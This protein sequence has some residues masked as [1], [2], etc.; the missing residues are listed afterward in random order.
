MKKIFNYVVSLMMALTAAFTYV[1]LQNTELKKKNEILMGSQ[2]ACLSEKEE[3]VFE[4]SRLKNEKNIINGL[5]EEAR[6]N[7]EACEERVHQ[8]LDT[9][10]AREKKSIK[11][12]LEMA[13]TF[14]ARMTQF[15][16]SLTGE[17]ERMLKTLEL[18]N[19]RRF[20]HERRIWEKVVR[21]TVR[22]MRGQALRRL[23]SDS[24]EDTD[25]G[26]SDPTR[27]NVHP[28]KARTLVIVPNLNQGVA[29]R[30]QKEVTPV[31]VMVWMGILFFL[32]KIILLFFR[33]RKKSFF[34]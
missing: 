27:L 5:Y 23:I 16:D 22:S 21:D 12:K 33:K 17:H 3:H 20:F 28:R 19:E 13:R 25:P 10:E 15:S 2:L 29:S 32:R 30:Q 26:F 9:I 4:I 14:S 31:V 18:A 34:G 24:R 7:A 1:V 8:L 6:Q 11:E